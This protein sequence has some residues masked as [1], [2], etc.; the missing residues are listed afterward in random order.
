MC[1]LHWLTDEQMTPLSPCF[2]KSHGKPRVDDKLVLSGI[3]LVNRWPAARI[4][5]RLEL[6]NPVMIRERGCGV[7]ANEDEVFGGADRLRAE[8]G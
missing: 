5:D 7:S 2:H 8:A 6:E 1:D 3:I 4:L